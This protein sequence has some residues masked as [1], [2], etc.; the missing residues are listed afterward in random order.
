MRVCEE[1]NR[2]KFKNAFLLA[3]IIIK[4]K[5]NLTQTSLRSI[6]AS[7]RYIGELVG[8]NMP[9]LNLQRCTYDISP[10]FCHVIE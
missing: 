2:G 6:L 8:E 7:S 10:N 3:C 1:L 5:G 9:S 4:V